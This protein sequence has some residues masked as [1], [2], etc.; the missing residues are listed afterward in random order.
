VRGN[1]LAPVLADPAG[2]SLDPLKETAVGGLRE[3][4][5]RRFV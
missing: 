1:H 5:S 4:K 2:V 3:I